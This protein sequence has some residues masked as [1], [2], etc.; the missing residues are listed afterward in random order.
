MPPAP[1]TTL[2]ERIARLNLQQDASTAPVAS[3]AIPKQTG[4]QGKISD[5][6]GRFQ[7]NAE[8][9]PLIPVGSFGLGGVRR[10]P[11]GDRTQEK[12]RVASL[13]GGR[14]AVPLGVV[15][16]PRSVSAGSPRTPRSEAGGSS[17]GNSPV[18][19]RASTP[20]LTDSVATIEPQPTAAPIS[21]ALSRAE[22]S[23]GTGA[24]TPGG[25]SVSSMSVE[26]GSYTS[27]AG[28]PDPNS[29]NL[30]EMD[31]APSP[32]SSPVL[33][34]LVEPT[35]NV[36]QADLPSP[37]FPPGPLKGH[38]DGLKAP[39][40][41]PS[42]ISVSSMVVEV[43]DDTTEG[44]SAMDTD[45]IET[46][47]T[48]EAPVPET[49]GEAEPTGLGVAGAAVGTEGTSEVDEEAQAAREKARE[50]A[51][52]MELDEYEQET[53][54]VTAPPPTD[55]ASPPPNALSSSPETDRPVLS[56]WVVD[57]PRPNE[58]APATVETSMADPVDP[59]ESG[60]ESEGGGGYGDI[61]DDFA[62]SEDSSS[63]PASAAGESGM[64]KVKCS[65]CSQDV[66]LMELADH[67]CGPSDKSP[68]LLSSPQHSPVTPRMPSLSSQEEPSTEADPVAVPPVESVTP[69]ASSA[70]LANETVSPSSP[71]LTRSESQHSTS[72]PKIDSFVPQ[73]ESLV[74]DD[75]LDLYE[76]DDFGESAPAPTPSSA[77]LD[78]P[79]GVPSDVSDDGLDSHLDQPAVS[80]PVAERRSSTDLPEDV[81]DEED[82]LANLPPPVARTPKAARGD[83]E[84]GRRSQSVYGS[85]GGSLYDD[86]DEENYEG[87][88]VAIVSRT[89]AS[90]SPGS[91][92]MA[93][94]G[95]A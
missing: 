8:A 77:S 24:Q 60:E 65:D 85:V 62:A 17:S 21:P 15:T 6:I 89:T 40:R 73:T 14:A 38:L 34:A 22:S 68:A 74:P 87:G 37:T 43:G 67:S 53:T 64:P 51:T 48:E 63:R 4:A 18:S 61:L 50:E 11:S 58:K 33:T 70:S 25:V 71:A 28:G 83:G 2:Q 39:L 92:S 29:I 84:G 41:S 57:S 26:G 31:I 78:I 35:V 13:G 79:T 23:V 94:T 7:K 75:V 46:P 90:H 44:A 12:G 5:K 42:S 82:T 86:D 10:E 9:A 81:D 91:S 47:R 27:E 30:G 80:Q 56:T 55:S 20:A 69:S 3:S 52:K 32:L 66:D 36:E 45:G 16:T 72:T 1:A 95:T 19:S 49:I 76:D 93:R 88:S 54:D 59:I